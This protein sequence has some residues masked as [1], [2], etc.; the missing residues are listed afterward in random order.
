M[1][2]KVIFKVIIAVATALLGIVT[3]KE[4]IDMDK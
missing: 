3:G 1:K 2:W 4:T